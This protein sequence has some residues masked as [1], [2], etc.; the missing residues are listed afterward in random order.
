MILQKIKSLLT[1]YRSKIIRFFMI[2]TPLVL[3]YLLF[4]NVVKIHECTLNYNVISG[5]VICDTIPGI[6]INSPWVL[7]S[8]IDTRPA[9]VCIDC[10][11]NNVTCELVAFNPNGYEA[12]LA[13]EG[14]SYYWLRN[15]LSFNSGNRN[16]WRGMD[17]VLRGYAF[18]KERYSFLT[19]E[20]K[21]I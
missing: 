14:W 5:N 9:R 16:E 20:N 4:V 7:V 1:P 18:D 3:F 13:K 8:N 15:R 6:K 12:F 11:C 10:A 17:N 2:L 19:Y 21:G